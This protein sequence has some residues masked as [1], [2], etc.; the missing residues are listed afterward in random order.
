MRYG[1]IR[2]LPGGGGGSLPAPL[3]ATLTVW[4]A[5]VRVP[6]REAPELAAIEKVTLP[7]PLPLAPL[8]IASHGVLLAASQL[9]QADAVRVDDGGPPWDRA[10]TAVG[11]T[12]NEQGSAPVTVT[13]VKIALV[14]MEGLWLVTARPMYT[15][16][17]IA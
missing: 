4:P 5:I 12:L 8:V 7:L 13:S 2:T 1:V 6:A 10:V 14:V 15:C 3:W 16:G 17:A 9:Q 11:E